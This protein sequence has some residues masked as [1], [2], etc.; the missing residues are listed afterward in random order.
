VKYLEFNPISFLAELNI[1]SFD[2]NI[3]SL[4]FEFNTILSEFKIIWFP[5]NS[6]IGVN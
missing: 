6:G 1:E 4:N 5:D 2:D 3:I